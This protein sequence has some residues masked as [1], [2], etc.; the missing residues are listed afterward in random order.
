MI[1]R[2]LNN[3]GDTLVEVLLATAVLSMVLAGAFSISNKA[4][5]VNQTA[6]ERTQ[7]SN[8]M[9]R[10][11]ELIRAYRDKEPA[12]FW[13]DVDGKI[14]TG[15][16]NPDFCLDTRANERLPGSFF[17]ADDGVGVDH[18]TLEDITREDGKMKDRYPD[19]FFDIW[20]EAVDGPAS[21]H[22]DFFIYG[23][24]EGIGGEV[25]QQSGLVMRLS[26]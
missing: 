5:R 6:G 18:P 26:R 8:L 4:T 24:W 7:V 2:R 16:E 15:G 1:I 10:E 23:C 21:E 20:V 25:Q 12:S 11:A 19:D 22:T 3:R 13:L 14:Q 17:M 9:Q